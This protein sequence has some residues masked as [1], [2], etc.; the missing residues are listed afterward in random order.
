M[1]DKDTR[2]D[3]PASYFGCMYPYIAA[4]N[5]TDIDYDGS[6]LWLT[7]CDNNRFRADSQEGLRTAKTS[8][9]KSITPEFIDE[10]S[11]RVANTV[12]RPFHKQSPILEAETDTLR[13]TIV[14]ESAAVSGRTFCIRKSPPFVRLTE[15]KMLR[16]KYLT[17]DMLSLLK[18]CVRAGMNFV[19]CGEPGVGKTEC[20]KF[21]SQLI[22]LNERVITIEDNPEWHYKAI[23]PGADCVELK[24]ND[25]MDYTAAIK[26]CLRLNPKWMMLSEVR[27]K[28]VKYLME[29]FSTGVRGMTTL[30]TDDVRKIPDRMMNMAGSEVGTEHFLNDIYSFIDVGVLIRRRGFRDDQGIVT[31]RRY[32]DQIGFFHRE[33]GVNETVLAADDGKMTGDE[34]PKSVLKKLKQA[35]V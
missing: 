10:F 13:I 1:G 15:E 6:R 18:R 12:S 7:D 29:G 34:L 9:Y 11:K 32:I 26:T 24:I 3:D 20:A 35:D 27:S 2:I 28:E 33:N 25:R 5:L 22:P 19:F 23:K 17:E 14:H 21:F 4:E 8:A 31:T 16:E 30:H